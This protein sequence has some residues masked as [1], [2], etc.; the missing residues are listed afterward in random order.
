MLVILPAI[1]F[2]PLASSQ[3]TLSITVST[4]RS[5]YVPGE[6]VAISGKVLDSHGN[7]VLGAGI[8]I[9][10]GD[11]PVYADG[12]ISDNSG[13]YVDSFV[14]QTGIAAGQYT[15]YATASKAGYDSA[16]QQT[17][18]TILPQAATTTSTQPSS[19]TSSPSKCFIATAT[20]GSEIA[21]EVALLRNFRDAEVMQ[22]SAGRSFM[23]AFNA[24]YYSFSPQV[25]SFIA[26]YGPVRPVMKVTLY[27]LIGI[28]YISSKIFQLSSFNVELAVTISGILAAL[29]IGFVYFGPIAILGSRLVNN[30]ASSRWQTWKRMV[31]A[32]CLISTLLLVLV[33]ANRLAVF[34]T[35]SAVAVVLSF[36][37]LG[38]FCA[39]SFAT[40]LGVGKKSQR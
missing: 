32:S 21:P 26:F 5:Q 40:L 22:T 1:L 19:Q 11:P 24:F 15:V 39:K 33:E 2:V 34:L 29:G 14:L 30:K 23:L 6:T 10:V 16:R 36:L 8:S 25:A 27:P 28:L 35:G 9:Q 3:G 31:L 12:I 17:Q 18:F 13:S 37:F 4:D 20:Y 38:A 7:P